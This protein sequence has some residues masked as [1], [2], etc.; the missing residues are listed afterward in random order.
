MGVTLTEGVVESVP[1]PLR[2]PEPT[3]GP[4]PPARLTAVPGDKVQYAL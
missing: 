3:R 1:I 4:G 2:S